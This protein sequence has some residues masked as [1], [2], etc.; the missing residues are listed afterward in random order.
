MMFDFESKVE[1][2]TENYGLEKLL[3]MNDI[4]EAYVVRLLIDR[5]MID[6]EEY[7]YLDE[8]MRE[9]ERSGE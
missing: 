6:L 7:F 2:L 1:A 9:W 8:E 4:S 5:Q 3:E